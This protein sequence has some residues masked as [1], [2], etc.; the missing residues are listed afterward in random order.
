MKQISI[1]RHAKA[2]AYADYE[3]DFQ[4]PL[5]GRGA[6]DAA[7]MARFLAVQASRPTW[8]ISSPALRARHTAEIAAEILELSQ[9]LSWDERIYDAGAETLLQVLQTAPEKVEHLLLVGHNP[10]MADL[11]AGLCAGSSDRVTLHLPTGGLVCLQSQ[12]Y[13]WHQ[14]RWGAAQLR[15]MISPKMVRPLIPTPKDKN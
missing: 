8:I 15:M 5:A 6:E 14:M 7:R 13:Y 11:A 9:A 10:G 1:L 4:R 2:A 3:I 12:V